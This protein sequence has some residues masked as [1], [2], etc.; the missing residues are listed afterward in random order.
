V[1]LDGTC[2]GLARTIWLDQVSD[3]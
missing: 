2:T 1:E 3:N